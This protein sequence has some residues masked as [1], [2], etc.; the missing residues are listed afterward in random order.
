MQTDTKDETIVFAGK[1]ASRGLAK[2]SVKPED[3]TAEW[4]DLGEDEKKV[5]DDW[6]VLLS[7]LFLCLGAGGRGGWKGIRADV[8][9]SAGDRFTFFSKR[10]NIV[11]KVVKA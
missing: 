5:L 10:Y 6:W 11:G 2:S 7:F 3:A 1:D 4:E 9:D 8:M